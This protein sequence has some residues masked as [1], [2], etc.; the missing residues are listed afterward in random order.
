MTLRALA[1]ACCLLLA[2]CAAPVAPSPTPDAD[3][4]G[5]EN[6]Y[7]A[8]DSV[9]VNASDGLNDSELDA[10]VGRTM[11]RVEVIRDLEFT[12]TVPVEIISRA[13]FQNQSD[14]DTTVDSPAERA[15]EQ[16]YE[17][18]MLVGEDRTVGQAFDSIYGGSVL[19]YYSSASNRI[20]IVS[21][22]ETPIVDRTTLAHE[23]MHALQDQ[24]LSLLGGADSPEDAMAQTGVVE[25]DASY[26]EE[27]YEARCESE[28]DCIDRPNGNSAGGLADEDLGLYL[29]VF[30]PYSE[31]PEFVHHRYERGGWDA[32]NEL[33]T[34]PPESSEQ[35]LHPEQYPDD[36]PERVIVPDRSTAAF[37]RAGSG[38]AIGE[39]TM[40]AMLWNQRTI[41]RGSLSQ[42][43][44]PYSPYNYSTPATKGW[45]G[46]RLVPYFAAETDGSEADG[47]VW[48]IRWE[49]RHD[50]REFEE[51]Y[52]RMLTAQLNATVQSDG[53]Y[54][55]PSGPFADA[56]RVTREG[57][58]V[59][60]VNAPT[61]TDLDR[62][63]GE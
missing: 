48:T 26:V 44:G 50:A 5:E 23:L 8:T 43:P 58:T 46:D 36:R 12:E 56:F 25:G 4:L 14:R 47:Y 35:L 17:A 1:L 38:A 22:N 59:R 62:V 27:R 20:V 49:S 7:T 34:R 28:W 16:R 39:A 57:T 3:R 15:R 40:F 61:V 6:G 60:I 13:E 42:N 29:T 19:G 37:D 11:A 24:R 55:V 52:R 31:G 30:A 63:H 9:A 21:A 33:Y 32:V 18:S 54:R 53:V 2:G 10:V 45:A 51:A 41:D